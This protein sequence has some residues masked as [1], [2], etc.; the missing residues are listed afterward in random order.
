[1]VID[2]LVPTLLPDGQWPRLARRAEDAGPTG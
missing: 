2:L 1:M